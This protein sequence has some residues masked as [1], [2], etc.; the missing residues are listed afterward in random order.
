MNPKF[1]EDMDNRVRRLLKLIEYEAPDYVISREVVLI[2]ETMKAHASKGYAEARR[3]TDYWCA[4][5]RAG[6]CLECDEPMT[7][8]EDKYGCGPLCEKHMAEETAQIDA[9]PDPEAELL[10]GE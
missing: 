10:N 7:S 3:E 4:R 6:L 1:K 9:L 5:L 2:V 8:G